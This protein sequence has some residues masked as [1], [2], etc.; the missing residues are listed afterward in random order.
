MEHG[1]NK[2][3]Q[4]LHMIYKK[5]T[6]YPARF[7]GTSCDWENQWKSRLRDVYLK[8]GAFKDKRTLESKQRYLEV[9]VVCDKK[10]IRFHKKIDVQTYVMTVM[11]M[12]AT[13]LRCW[14]SF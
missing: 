7:C 3:G 5:N 12:V 9:L 10:F 8:N 2:K 11:N 1:P 6:E 4:Y 14:Q 13:I